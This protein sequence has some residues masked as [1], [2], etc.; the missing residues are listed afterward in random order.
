MNDLHDEYLGLQHKRV[1]TLTKKVTA[2]LFTIRGDLI[3]GTSGLAPLQADDY[4]N[5]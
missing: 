5:A 1:V 3:N 2:R 4:H